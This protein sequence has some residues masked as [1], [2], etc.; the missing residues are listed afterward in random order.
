MYADTGQCCYTR[1]GGREVSSGWQTVYKS[2][3][4]PF[5]AVKSFELLQNAN[6]T[7]QIPIDDQGNPVELMDITSDGAYLFFSRVQYGLAD[8]LGRHNNF[9]AHSYILRFNDVI[10]DPN[11]VA[12]ILNSSFVEMV[13]LVHEGRPYRD[14]PFT[15]ASAMS[16]CNLTAEHYEKLLQTVYIHLTGASGSVL[17]I[18]GVSKEYFRGLFYLLFSGIPIALRKS[19]SMATSLINV[20]SPKKIVLSKDAITHHGSFFDLSTTENNVLTPHLRSR[21]ER[22]QFINF[23]AFNAHQLTTSY[24]SDLHTVALDMGDP[25]GIDE[26]V[27]KNAFLILHGGNIEDLAEEQVQKQVYDLLRSPCHGGTFEKQLT[28]LL[29][30]MIEQQGFLD[31]DQESILLGLI[32]QE[33]TS[34]ALKEAGITIHVIRLLR[35]AHPVA[36]EELLRLNP[37]L[38]QRYVSILEATREGHELLDSFYSSSLDGY[39]INWDILDQTY[40]RI[41]QLDVKERSVATLISHSNALLRRELSKSLDPQSCF[42]KYELLISKCVS[43]DQLDV[44]LEEGKSVYWEHRSLAQFDE[45]KSK[46]YRY[47]GING[48]AA[49]DLFN[50]LLRLI[51]SPRLSTR[52]YLQHVFAAAYSLYKMRKHKE[53]ETLYDLICRNVYLEEIIPFFAEWYHLATLI[54]TDRIDPL[55]DLYEFASQRRWGNMKNE[56]GRAL[57]ILESASHSEEDDPVSLYAD[58]LMDELMYLDQDYMVPVDIWLRL[59]ASYGDEQHAFVSVFDHCQPQIFELSNEEVVFSSELLQN[60]EFL[61][62][63]E[64]RLQKDKGA[65]RRQLKSW[66]KRGRDYIKIK[67]KQT[68]NLKQRQD[69]EFRRRKRDRF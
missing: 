34:E 37:N 5:D 28:R 20:A 51:E 7:N 32:S 10:L 56:F 18:Y 15:V 62:Y 35:D 1:V 33:D 25:S 61:D 30:R 60:E 52:A 23:Y 55:F 53:F 39:S 54:Q 41:R 67:N 63:F 40:E 36:V 57:Q 66:L 58:I 9:F 17:N 45:R 11:Q 2:P 8:D 38:R 3:H 21:F 59:A 24:F 27:L 13:D 29:S 43:D 64:E 19:L 46:E 31:E 16:L 26:L 42:E 12:T 4:L 44:A 14:V 6:I 69:G 50:N 48:N 65:S 49:S 47:F 22:N 68:Q